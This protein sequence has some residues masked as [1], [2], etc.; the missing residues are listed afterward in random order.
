MD[1]GSEV[2]MNFTP[3]NR[4]CKKMAYMFIFINKV[5]SNSK[6]VGPLISVNWGLPYPKS[7]FKVP[8]SYTD[9]SGGDGNAAWVFGSPW[10]LLWPSCLCLCKSWTLFFDYC[11]PHILLHG[12]GLGPVDVPSTEN[13]II[14]SKSH[15]KLSK[16]DIWMLSFIGFRVLYAQYACWDE[17]SFFL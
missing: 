3:Q 12:A 5:K 11:C 10:S 17:N 9:G 7:H 16:P 8:S 13:I 2:S 14:Q 15:T 6:V 4:L 1:I